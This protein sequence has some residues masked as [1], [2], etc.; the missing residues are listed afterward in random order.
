M[1]KFISLKERN[2]KTRLRDL[3]DLLGTRV[4]HAA[5]FQ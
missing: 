2:E 5:D 1:W 3:N 4:F